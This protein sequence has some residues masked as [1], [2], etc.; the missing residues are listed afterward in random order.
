MTDSMFRFMRPTIS[1]KT[2]GLNVRMDLVN[3]S[4]GP[5]YIPPTKAESTMLMCSHTFKF[6]DTPLNAFSSLYRGFGRWID[7]AATYGEAATAHCRGIE[8]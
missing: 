3:A 4:H 7:L 1:R 8:R 2:S 6:M 5:Q